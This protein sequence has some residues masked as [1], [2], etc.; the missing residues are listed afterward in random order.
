MLIGKFDKLYQSKES[1]NNALYCF[2]I[3]SGV[4]PTKIKNSRY[5][6]KYINPDLFYMDKSAGIIPSNSYIDE[7]GNVYCVEA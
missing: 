5:L 4:S 3:I 6:R 2:D 1:A 7:S